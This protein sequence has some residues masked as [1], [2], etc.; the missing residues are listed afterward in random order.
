M[1]LRP[2]W[3]ANGT[4]YGYS[5]AYGGPSERQY[6]D[7]VASFQGMWRH[8]HDLFTAEGIAAPDLEWV[9]SVNSPDAYSAD[10]SHIA[11]DLYP[12]DAY[13]DWVAVD[14]YNFG[15]SATPGWQ[16]PDQIFDSM[17]QRL[18]ALAPSKPIG[19]TEVGCTTNGANQAAKSDWIASYWSWLQ[20]SVGSAVRMTIW[21]NADK[22]EDRSF[23]DFAAFG[24]AAGTSTYTDP[25][26][27]ATFNAYSTYGAAISADAWL[28][29]SDPNQPTADHRSAVPRGIALPFSG[30]AELEQAVV[31][32]AEMVRNLVHDGDPHPSYDVV[33]VTADAADRQPVD[34]DPVGEHT[35]VRRRPSCQR[36]ALVE[37]EQ[38]HRVA[39]VLDSHRDV[40]HHP[41]Q[42][43]RDAVERHLDQPA[44]SVLVHVDRHASGLPSGH[45]G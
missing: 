9:Y 24:G 6:Q 36:N 38:V 5:P 15:S 29:G 20:G 14:G 26:T 41:A 18:H 30:P 8:L 37:A 45:P 11:E 35:G 2:D 31:V 27:S 23:R 19:V 22:T 1:Y 21:F 44:E 34:G 3:E 43:V 16:T 32:D 33:R 17:I 7:N 12:G 10:S 25:A 42:A 40:A 28:Q 39:L 13:V 4:W